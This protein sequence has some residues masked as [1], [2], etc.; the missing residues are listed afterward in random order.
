MCPIISSTVK[1]NEMKWKTNWAACFSD[2]CPEKKTKF[3]SNHDVRSIHK[4]II[5][6]NASSFIL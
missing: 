6:A 5:W 1:T 3:V 4:Y 2:V